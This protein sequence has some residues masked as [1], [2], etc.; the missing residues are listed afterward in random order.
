MDI[1]PYDCLYEIFRHC[2]NKIKCKLSKTCTNFYSLKTNYMKYLLKT[3]YPKL[4]PYLIILD[5]STLNLALSRMISWNQSNAFAMKPFIDTLDA[6]GIV[7]ICYE[8]RSEPEYFSLLKMIYLWA[9]YRWRKKGN[10]T[11]MSRMWFN[12]DAKEKNGFYKGTTEQKLESYQYIVNKV[13]IGDL[14]MIL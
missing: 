3:R 5:T 2:T 8:K 9:G 6:S 4:E 14:K 12:I 13:I 10:D 11:A 1:L 7:Y